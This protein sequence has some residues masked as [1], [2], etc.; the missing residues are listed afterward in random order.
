MQRLSNFSGS[1]T[2][3]FSEESSQIFSIF[4][5]RRRCAADA[6]QTADATAEQT[7]SRYEACESPL[8]KTNRMHDMLS[9]AVLKW[10]QEGRKKTSART[11]SVIK[12]IWLCGQ[13]MCTATL[14]PGM[15][16]WILTLRAKPSNGCQSKNYSYASSCAFRIGMKTSSAAK[17]LQKLG[18]KISQK[19]QLL[20]RGPIYSARDLSL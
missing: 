9:W 18:D 3:P 5:S 6:E 15:Y 17:R 1:L 16:T 19:H 10:W 13:K 12:F 11:S 7:T 4:T 14:S 20:I 8:Q 2:L